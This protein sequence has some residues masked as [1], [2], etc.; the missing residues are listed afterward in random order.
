MVVPIFS[1][2]VLSIAP[3]CS[4]IVRCVTANPN[5]SGNFD[6]SLGWEMLIQSSPSFFSVCTVMVPRGGDDETLAKVACRQR[7]IWASWRQIAS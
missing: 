7:V 2:M 6:S 1:E 5:P 4:I 3:L